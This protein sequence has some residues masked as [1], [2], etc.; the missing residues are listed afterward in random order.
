MLQRIELEVPF[1]E[2]MGCI[3][4]LL[5]D[6]GLS[7]RQLSDPAAMLLL[8]GSSDCPE[9]SELRVF[10]NSPAFGNPGVLRI[11]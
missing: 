7:G 4:L 8:S 11:L 2:G 3:E 9:S 6:G 5:F 10:F 1:T